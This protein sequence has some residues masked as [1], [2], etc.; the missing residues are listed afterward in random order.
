M[1]SIDKQNYLVEHKRT[2]IKHFVFMVADF[3][4]DK[5]L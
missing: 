3:E 2:C 4:D 1:S 5:P